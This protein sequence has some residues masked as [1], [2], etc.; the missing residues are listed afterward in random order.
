MEFLSSK[1]TFDCTLFNLG[2]LML[3]KGNFSSERERQRETERDKE[4]DRERQRDR[5]RDRETDRETFN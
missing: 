5:D 3:Y 4:T 1:D 2:F